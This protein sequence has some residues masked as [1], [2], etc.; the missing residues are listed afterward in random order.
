MAKMRKKPT[1]DQLLEGGG[2]GGGFGG[3]TSIMPKLNKPAKEGFQ[4][5]SPEQTNAKSVTP[6]PKEDVVGS[7]RADIGRIRQG[8][9]APGKTE[10]GRAMQQEAGGRAITRTMGRAGAAGAAGLGGA[11]MGKRLRDRAD[12]EK[13]RP[14]AKMGPSMDSEEAPM[15]KPRPRPRP[16]PMPTPMPTGSVREGQNENIDDETRAK[17]MESVGMKDG[18]KVSTSAKTMG[19]YKPRRPGTT[20]EDSMTSDDIKKM[21][22]QK[23][24]AATERKTKTAPTTKTEMGKLFAKGGSVSSRADGIAQR[25]K[26]RGK[27]C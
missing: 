20:Y 7:Q 19:A 2:G 22:A 10:R 17:A 21:Q 27:I 6:H 9:S 25:G 15:P 13:M 23:D 16:R 1:D 11:E 14:D 4:Y 5:R 26:T 3:R 18:G 24:E 12:T 8:L